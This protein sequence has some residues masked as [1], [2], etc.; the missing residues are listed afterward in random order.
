M[1]HLKPVFFNKKYLITIQT[2]LKQIVMSIFL[3][4]TPNFNGF[5]KIIDVQ[6]QQ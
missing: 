3:T 4:E 6:N 5:L 2:H 1:I